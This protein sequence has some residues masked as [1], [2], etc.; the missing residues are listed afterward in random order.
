MQGLE[1]IWY[2]KFFQD[3]RKMIIENKPTEKCHAC[4]LLDMSSD[5]RKDLEIYLDFLKEKNG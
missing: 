3:I 1:N 2:G 5:L 4:G